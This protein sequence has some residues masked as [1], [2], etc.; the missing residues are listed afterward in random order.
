MKTLAEQFQEL[1]M[2]YYKTEKSPYV[3]EIKDDYST[4]FADIKVNKA[5]FFP[6]AIAIYFMIKIKEEVKG[7][8]KRSEKAVSIKFA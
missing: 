8:K 3:Y 2:G 4:G 5:Y 6:K 1:I 7:D